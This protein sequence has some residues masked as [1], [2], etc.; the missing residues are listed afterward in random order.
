MTD[1]V[2]LVDPRGKT[3][4]HKTRL[5]ADEWFAQNPPHRWRSVKDAMEYYTGLGLRIVT[6]DANYGLFEAETRYTTRRATFWLILLGIPSL[7][8]LVPLVMWWHIAKHAGEERP[9]ITVRRDWEY[10]TEAFVEVREA[11]N[12]PV[13]VPGVLE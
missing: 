4:W 7:G 13:L 9:S 11:G 10:G 5:S 1:N 8:T 2:Y 12:R 3:P 6:V